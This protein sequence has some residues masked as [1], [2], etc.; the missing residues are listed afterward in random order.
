MLMPAD[1][2]DAKL[3]SD[4]DQMRQGFGVQLV[5]DMPPMSLNR[6]LRRAEL[7]SDLFVE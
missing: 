5:H 2:F 1:R 7:V 4:S 6:A 3:V